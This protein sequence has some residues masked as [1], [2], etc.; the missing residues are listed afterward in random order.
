MVVNLRWNQSD[1]FLNIY[2]DYSK[3][4]QYPENDTVQAQSHIDNLL[5]FGITVLLSCHFVLIYLTLNSD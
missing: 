5:S 4:I 1:Y 3:F 2:M